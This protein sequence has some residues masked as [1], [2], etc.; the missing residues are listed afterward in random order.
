MR[1]NLIFSWK[2]SIVWNLLTDYLQVNINVVNLGFDDSTKFRARKEIRDLLDLFVDE[3]NAYRLIWDRPIKRQP[4]H[5]DICRLADRIK[6]VDEKEGVA[7]FSFSFLLSPFSFLLSPFSFLLSPFSFFLSP[8]S[9]FF[10]FFF[11][12]F[13]FFSSSFSFSSSFRCVTYHNQIAV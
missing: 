3:A 2:C 6:I 7:S 11:S 12:F 10:S 4:V 5:K 1:S 13:F 9:S 8:F